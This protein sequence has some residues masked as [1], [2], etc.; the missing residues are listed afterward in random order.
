MNNKLLLSVEEA[1]DALSLGRSKLF[2]LIASGELESFTIGRR[3]V[4]P[5]QALSDF[6]ERQRRERAPAVA[7]R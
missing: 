1:A 7:S 5:L 2:E 3:R 6:V 4:I